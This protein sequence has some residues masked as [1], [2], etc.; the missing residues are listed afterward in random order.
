MAAIEI[1]IP[2]NVSMAPQEVRIPV[3][4]DAS[5]LD[6]GWISET[7]M[8]QDGS[9]IVRY[10]KTDMRLHGIL[11]YDPQNAMTRIDVY[12]NYKLTAPTTW[13]LRIT[14]MT[15]GETD[16]TVKKARYTKTQ[17]YIVFS[18]N[19]E[20]VSIR[21]AQRVIANWPEMELL[22]IG[23][24]VNMPWEN[25]SGTTYDNQMILVAYGK[26]QKEGDPETTLTWMGI[27]MSQYGQ[28][29][30]P[31]DGAE[32]EEA[33]EAKAQTGLH[34]YGRNGGTYTA[35]E[36]EDGDE[37]PYED[38][39][40]IY[41]NEIDNSSTRNGRA[42]LWWSH[43]SMRQYLNSDGAAG[44]WWKAQHIGDCEPG[45]NASRRGYLAGLSTEDLTALQKIRI[46]TGGEDDEDVAR[47][48]RVWIPSPW[49]MYGTNGEST[50]MNFDR[51][52]Q[53]IVGL[54]GSHRNTEIEERATT[55]L[56]IPGSAATTVLRQDITAG[57]MGPYAVIGSNSSQ[58][59]LTYKKG[60]VTRSPYAGT[61]NL[62]MRICVAVG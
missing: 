51:Y 48:D 9:R 57:T 15:L 16:V 47:F 22:P 45:N 20:T 54:T 59:G 27:F 2:L 19:T 36:L 35:L 55:L 8:Q 28:S 56:T 40:H 18:T 31:F 34:Y 4:I 61:N 3:D 42:L 44:T 32:Q 49:E 14:E 43:S 12:D 25:S 21:H 1:S 62:S 50:S 52:W 5:L 37:I 13:G 60:Q 24:T 10:Y 7:E 6:G 39:E 58:S 38:Y 26:Y 11:Y 30:V 53:G 46:R 41:H 33:T 17:G 23:Y 29:A